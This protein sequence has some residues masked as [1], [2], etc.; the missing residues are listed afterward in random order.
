[1]KKVIAGILCVVMLLC[2]LPCGAN[3]ATEKT[4]SQLMSQI[5]RVY[6]RTLAMSEMDSLRGYCGLMTGAQLYFMGINQYL[7][8]YD[9][10]DQY[11]TY[12]AMD[13]T[14][15]GYHCRV[16]SAERYSLLQALN[17]ITD[18][19]TKNVYNILVG[20]EKTT[21]E[22]GSRYGHAMV[23]HGIVDGYVYFVEGFYT[24]VAGP[25]GTPIKCT[26]PQFVAFYDDWTTYEGLVVFEEKDYRDQCE[27]ADTDLYV[28]V[29]ERE[30]MLATLPGGPYDEP[31]RKALPGE[32]LYATGIY[33]NTLNQY[34]YRIEDG[35]ETVFVR[36]DDVQPV[37][38]TQG[39][40]ELSGVRL[41]EDLKEGENFRP[42]GNIRSAFLTLTCSKA[43][44]LDAK[45]QLL[46]E[47]V[48]HKEGKNHELFGRDTEKGLDTRSLPAGAYIYQIITT[49]L[50]SYY[51]EE[52]IKQHPEE[53]VLLKW[54]F[55]VGDSAA[56]KGAEAVQ[57]K[58]LA[59][60]WHLLEGKWY[61]YAEGEPKT[62]WVT[63]G[64]TKYYFDQT[65]AALT[66]W[67]EVDGKLHLFTDTGAMRIGWAEAE[68]GQAYLTED[69]TPAVGKYT[70]PEGTFYFSDRGTVI[71]NIWVTEGKDRYFFR[72]DG[73]MATGWV[74]LPQG[75]FCFREDGRL[76]GQTGR[77]PE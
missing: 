33:K 41:P 1:M 10:K 22:A 11:D 60:G 36:C 39:G 49:V 29:G 53:V 6:A 5:R 55:V 75:S 66:G 31:V 3:A 67:T 70:T 76:F 37:Y 7:L 65:G 17:R 15:G 77:I 38:F 58:L 71:R 12:A 44:I 47:D 64:Q 27:F 73:T 20:F 51:E 23:I 25:E 30:T 32:R 56:P 57:E 18:K 74:D 42:A 35:E 45:G 40:V 24:S 46:M 72:E 19:G 48:L 4:E 8:P 28:Q 61:C 16:Y 2:A 62:G 21:T 43:Q 26:I 59:D 52:T 13:M 9:G 68:D 50:S 14:S 34:F 54:D 63:E 69:G